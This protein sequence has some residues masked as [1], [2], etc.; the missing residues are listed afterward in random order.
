MRFDKYVCI[1]VDAFSTGKKFAL[2]FKSKGYDCIH[3]QS[4][5]HLPSNKFSHQKSDFVKNLVYKGNLNSILVTLKNYNIKICLPGSES[6][7]ELADL[8]S[9]ALGLSCNGHISNHAR[10]NKFQMIEA[11]HQKGLETVKHFKSKDVHEIIAWFNRENIKYPIVLKPLESA[12]GDG[13]FFCN[14]EN[15]IIKAHQNIMDRPNFF[16]EKNREVLAE[17]FNAGQEY[18]INTVSCEIKEEKI[19][20][21]FVVEIWRV[22]RKPGTTIYDRAEII[23]HN[24]KEYPILSDYTF[25]VL[26]ALQIKI[27]A[28]TTEVKYSADGKPVLIESAARVMGGA[29]LS[30]SNELFGYTQL[31]LAA[32][33]YLNPRMFINIV[34]TPPPTEKKFGMDVILISDREGE[35]LA[36]IDTSELER[37]ETLH[38]FKLEGNKGTYL[39]K[40]INSLTSPGEIYLISDDRNK[41]LIDYEKIRKIES[42]GLYRQTVVA[43]S[44]KK[45]T[46]RLLQPSYQT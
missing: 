7:V 41:L 36:N 39:Y 21:H 8:L 46:T 44:Q 43:P 37:L 18:I 28:A 19:V 26:D 4:S 1:V 12:N 14:N 2:E 20:K 34:S 33:A 38:S 24:E 40:T 27:G 5:T 9:E 17:S 16:G 29:P 32:I 23:H 31:S 13:V 42:N 35:L 25:K 22:Y 30:L 3:I 11:V 10:R 6:G 45:V 15:E